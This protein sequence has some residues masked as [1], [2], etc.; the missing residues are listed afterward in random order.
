M[1]VLAVWQQIEIVKM[2]MN[3]NC[4]NYNNA[5]ELEYK[6]IIGTLLIDR[7]MVWREKI[8]Y[9]EK[10]IDIDSLSWVFPV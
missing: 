8:N 5:K 2:T 9:K 1:S 3:L 6:W 7:I 4:W 10:I